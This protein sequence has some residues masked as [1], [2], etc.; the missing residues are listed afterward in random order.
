MKKLLICILLIFGVFLCPWP[1]WAQSLPVMDLQAYNQFLEKNK[2]K[3]IVVDFWATWCGPCRK[4]LPELQKCRDV[5]PK[6]DLT[7]IGI[8]L[9]FNPETLATY[10]QDN[11]L[12]YPVYLAEEN[13]AEQL[14]V[15]AIPLL[16][17]YDVAGQ[18]QIVEEGLTP[19]DTLCQNIDNLTA[20][21]ADP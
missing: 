13:L 10:L 9:D 17:V 5:F 8:S 6:E 12:N 14:E 20:D 3:V 21:P 7:L 18:L 16:F 19:H 11:P 4:K 1:G 15:Q 2:G